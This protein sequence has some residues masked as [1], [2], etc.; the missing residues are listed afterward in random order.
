M[1]KVIEWQMEDTNMYY[2]KNSRGSGRLCEENMLLKHTVDELIEEKAKLQKEY[3][4]LKDRYTMDVND[5]NRFKHRCDMACGNVGR[6]VTENVKLR[7]EVKDLEEQNVT[8][9]RQL[10]EA[11]ADRWEAQT[12]LISKNASFKILA[13]SVYGL[14]SQRSGLT[15]IDRV[16]FN[17][18]AT[19]VFWSDGTKTVVK[20][21]DKRKFDPEKGLAM[22]ITKK[23]LG[24]KGSYYDELRKWLPNDKKSG[25]R[26]NDKK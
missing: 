22:A 21:T 6:F 12:K 18:P 26:N 4:G 15:N 19:I 1:N 5:V 2:S 14:L 17:D 9:Q 23:A 20:N 7:K 25:G 13:N 3:E 8:L 24:N 11:Y 10:E 16:I